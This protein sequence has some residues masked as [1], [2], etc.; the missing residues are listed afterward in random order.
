MRNLLEVRAFGIFA[1]AISL[2]VASF[3][4][5]DRAGRIN[6]QTA[7]RSASV[8]ASLRVVSAALSTAQEAE[9]QVGFVVASGGVKPLKV[10][11]PI[12]DTIN[13]VATV[14]FWVAVVSGVLAIGLWPLMCVGMALLVLGLT[15]FALFPSMASRSALISQAVSLGLLLAVVVPFAFVVA[16]WAA[17]VA[18]KTK[19]SEA[20]A[21]LES[22]SQRA[23]DFVGSQTG[24][25]E[26]GLAE[27]SA[28]GF[29][30][31]VKDGST[32]VRDSVVGSVSATKHFA[33]TAWFYMQKADELAAALVAI[34][35]I[36]LLKTI[37]MPALALAVC[38]GLLRRGLDDQILSRLRVERSAL[39][40]QS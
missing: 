7:L 33:D 35:A 21:V 13:R 20:M 30:S 11:E 14:V 2:L 28:R 5:A 4:L 34:V 26:S 39:R 23:G 40:A 10:L 1:I 29:F 38:F 15:S 12:D 25:L 9:V 17:E 19:W 36:F 32:W 37:A 3:A 31:G 8:Y 6:E 22:A 18:T 16:P 24:E 27:D